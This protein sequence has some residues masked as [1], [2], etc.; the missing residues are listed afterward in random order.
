M[1]FLFIDTSTR[2]LTVAISSVD[3]IFC[4]NTSHNT[5]EHSKYAVKELESAFLKANLKPNDIDK[6]IVV[7]GPGSFTG[8]RI[9]V[10]IAKTYAWALDKEVIP[11]SSLLAHA[12]SYNG[13]D[14]YVSVLDARRDN[15]YAAI[16]NSKYE[17]ILTEQHI[18]IKE[19]I[20]YISTLQGN[21]IV[22]G[23]ININEYD[24]KQV[25]LDILNIVKHCHK[26]QSV[27]P[28]AL[29]PRYLKR[30]EAEEKLMGVNK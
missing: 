5:N 10:T 28:H 26:E 2:D 12:L 1:K 15:V 21:I 14:Y 9:G 30:V 16:Y 6:V 8:V 23:D 18:S 24:S 4:L 22:I 3:E 17:N 7:N 25:K 29:K 11:V 20:D 27:S 19:L 13:Y